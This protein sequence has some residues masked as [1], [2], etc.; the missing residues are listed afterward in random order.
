MKSNRNSNNFPNIFKIMGDPH[1]SATIEQKYNVVGHAHYFLQ[2]YKSSIVL[3]S[4]RLTNLTA[5]L[6]RRGLDSASKYSKHTDHASIKTNPRS[7]HSHVVSALQFDIELQK[8]YSLFCERRRYVIPENRYSSASAVVLTVITWAQLPRCS[9]FLRESAFW[10]AHCLIS[11]V[12]TKY[13][14][15]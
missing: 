4:C 3:Y 8:K 1:Q 14:F 15:Q 5:T 11:E 6:T 12:A 10:R 9:R 7:I 2:V 13:I